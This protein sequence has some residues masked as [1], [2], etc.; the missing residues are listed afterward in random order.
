M[1]TIIHAIKDVAYWKWNQVFINMLKN[2]IW[3]GFKESVMKRL[4]VHY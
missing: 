4:H 3:P 1:S 2:P